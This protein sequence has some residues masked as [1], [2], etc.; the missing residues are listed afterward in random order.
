MHSDKELSHAL[1]TE[2]KGENMSPTIAI[3]IMVILSK[4]KEKK[5]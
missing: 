4:E 3:L 2:A 5:W 1:V